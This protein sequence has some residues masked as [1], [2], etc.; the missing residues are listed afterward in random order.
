MTIPYNTQKLGWYLIHIVVAS[1]SK[2]TLIVCSHCQKVLHQISSEVLS[3]LKFWGL[4]L[5]YSHGHQW[6]LRYFINNPPP[7]GLVL[8]V[9]SV[10]QTGHLNVEWKS[11]VRQQ[12]PTC[13]SSQLE[14][15]VEDKEDKEAEE[16][17]VAQQ[18]GLTAS[19]EL[20][21]PAD[22]G[23]EQAARRV[24]VRVLVWDRGPIR[25]PSILN[26]EC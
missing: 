13:L 1:I 20:L 26:W 5:K 3:W 2:K 10:A 21:D 12:R 19:G 16:Q 17:H 6:K 24:K 11:R 23:A 22:G 8:R 15:P 25:S 14:E 7:V 4:S 18:F 9:I